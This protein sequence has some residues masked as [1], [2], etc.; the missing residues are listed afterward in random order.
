MPN[1]RLLVQVATMC[2]LALIEKDNVLSAIRMID[3]LYVASQPN[4]NL[5]P[6]ET[7]GVRVTLLISL[8]SGD[9]VGDREI[10]IVLRRPTGTTTEIHRS[11]LNFGGGEHGQNLRIFTVMETTEPG[12]FWFDVMEAENVLTSIP[13]KLIHGRPDQR[14]STL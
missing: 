6:D 11:T 12:L 1:T 5:G 9:V 7:L 14:P 3:T 13:F 10:R 2:E 4:I 8:K